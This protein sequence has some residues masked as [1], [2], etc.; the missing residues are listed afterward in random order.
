VIEFEDAVLAR[1]GNEP[2]E[3]LRLKSM[4]DEAMQRF[5]NDLSVVHS[6]TGLTFYV[7]VIV[8]EEDDG[9]G[10]ALEGHEEGP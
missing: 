9:E 2:E 3:M 5:A 8:R 4:L 1:L 6:Q 10:E 7:Q